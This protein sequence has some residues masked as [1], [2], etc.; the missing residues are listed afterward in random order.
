M[1]IL[2][3]LDIECKISSSLKHNYLAIR[4]SISLTFEWILLEYY[5]SMDIYLRYSHCECFHH[6][7]GMDKMYMVE[8]STWCPHLRHAEPKR[9]RETKSWRNFRK[10]LHWEVQYGSYPDKHIHKKH[11][12]RKTCANLSTQRST[13]NHGL[14]SLA[15]ESLCWK[16]Q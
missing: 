7:Y 3:A 14:L 13:F 2:H 6:D 11:T 5:V 16:M 1:Y 10:L 9:R 4:Y 8:Q 15:T 12:D